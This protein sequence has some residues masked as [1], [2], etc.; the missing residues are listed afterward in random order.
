MVSKYSFEV[1]LQF[2]KTHT[3]QS[4]SFFQLSQTK[5]MLE[6]T[7]ITKCETDSDL[8]CL[9]AVHNSVATLESPQTRTHKAGVPVLIWNHAHKLSK[10][11]AQCNYC[12]KIYMTCN[13]STYSLRHHIMV[14][15]GVQRADC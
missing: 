8:F 11:H 4:A 6:T 13:G 1:Y 7:Q 12:G 15:H 5:I 9:I 2:D 10:T 3:Y 14:K